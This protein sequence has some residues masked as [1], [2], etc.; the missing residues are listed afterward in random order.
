VLKKKKFLIGGLVVFLAIVYLGYTG[1][2]GSAAYYYTV[3]EF[4]EHK[5]PVNGD[6]VRINGQV[7]PGSVEQEDGGRTLRFTIA[8]GAVSL[9]VVYHG[10]VPDTFKAGSEIVVEGH[11]DSASTFEASTLMPKCASKYA[12][13]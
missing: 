7:A 10:I 3:S 6:V 1:F 4:V 9:P 8:E 2:M 11:L 5:T 13:K 12:S